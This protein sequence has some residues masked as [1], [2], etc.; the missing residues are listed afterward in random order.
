M[1]RGKDYITDLEDA[2]HC[3][4]IS[5]SPTNIKYIDKSHNWVTWEV[6]SFKKKMKNFLFTLD[7]WS[8]RI[9]K[10]LVF[11]R[12]LRKIFK[13]AC[14]FSGFSCFVVEIHRTRIEKHVLLNISLFYKVHHYTFVKY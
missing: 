3:R 14:S 10:T 13:N 5:T 1:M 7:F 4:T 8:K 6:E 12:N 9:Y 11:L 2:M